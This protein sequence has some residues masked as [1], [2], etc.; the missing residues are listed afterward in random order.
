M[1]GDVVELLADE[2]APLRAAVLRDGTLDDAVVWDGDDDPATM[3]LGVVVDDELVAI[4]SWMRRPHPGRP[5]RVAFQVRGMA[6]DPAHRGRG[7]G[8][9]LLATGIERC[10]AAGADTVWARARDTALGFYVERGFAVDG[11][12]YI[13]A[14]TGL[15]HHD[16]ILDL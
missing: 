1:S 9:R 3:H 14:T 16:V 12:G 13:D 10:R 6:T 4:G 11:D 7:H 8:S 5:G 2:T 15:A